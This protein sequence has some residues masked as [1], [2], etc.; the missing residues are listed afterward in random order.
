VGEAVAQAYG[1]ASRAS[2]P[3]ARGRVIAEPIVSEVDTDLCISC[4]NCEVVCEYGAI[5]VENEYAEVNPVLCKGCGTCA[6]E[7]PAVAIS[8]RHFTND[9]LTAMIR[10]A[11]N[12]E[13]KLP[14]EKGEPQALA[15]FCNWCAYAGADLAGVSR[16]QYPTTIKIIRVMCTGR[17]DESHILLAFLLG[18]DGVLIGGCH[19]GTCHY[20][21]GNLK[22]KK[23]IQKVKRWLKQAGLEPDRLRLEWI[24]AGEGTKLAEVVKDFS[25]QLQKLGSSPLKPVSAVPVNP[26]DQE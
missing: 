8:M 21:S 4:R 6:V 22:A 5:K 13:K 12:E 20:I 26:R 3:L 15:F 7:C 10:T 11:L 14:S 25:L 2:I 19:L 16:F 18:S 24:S 17:I 9:Q 1:A 23:R